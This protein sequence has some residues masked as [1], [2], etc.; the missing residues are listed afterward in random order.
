MA[1]NRTIL[2]P[3]HLEH[4]QVWEDL[5]TEVNIAFTAIDQ[6]ISDMGLLRKPIDTG[7][8]IFASNRTAGKLTRLDAIRTLE[9]SLTVQSCNNLGF[10]FKTSNVLDAEDYTRIAIN[11]GAYYASTKGTQGWQNF[12]AFCLNAVFT[13]E[14]LWTTD[15]VTFVTEGSAG[16]PVWDG[17]AWY[18]TTHVNLSYAGEFSGLTSATI[19]DFFYYFANINLVLESISVDYMVNYALNASI[20]CMVEIWV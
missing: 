18:P 16:T 19:Q 1:I 3:E 11:L 4:N 5:M 10:T 7:D 9:R 8:S 2:V 15:Y 12:L 14:Q 6:G 17:G 13:V 20:S